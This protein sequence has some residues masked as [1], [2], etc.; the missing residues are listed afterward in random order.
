MPGSRAG[1]LRLSP[2]YDVL[3][4]NSGQGH[5]EFVVGAEGRDSTL[6]NA[7]SQCTLFGLEGAAAA[8]EVLRIIAVVDTWREH[9]MACG[10]AQADIDSLAQRIDGAELLQERRGFSP[11]GYATPAPKRRRRPFS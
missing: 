7:M 4:S 9:F 8:Q 10:V 1:R 11:A 2:A 5:Q 6:A 3:P